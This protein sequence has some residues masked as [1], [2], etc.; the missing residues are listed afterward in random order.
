KRIYGDKTGLHYCDK[1]TDTLNEADALVIVTEW[2]QFR[3]PD[4]EQ[5]A[6]K[7]ADRVIFDGRNMYEPKSVRH[8][9]L[10]YYAIGRS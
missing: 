3:S 9:G 1:Q 2:K 4:L 6:H 10:Q 7:L 8:A 5:L